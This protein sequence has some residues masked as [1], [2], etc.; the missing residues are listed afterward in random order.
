K[1]GS[2][3]LRGRGNSFRGD[4]MVAHSPPH[5]VFSLK[6]CELRHQILIGLQERGI[7]GMVLWKIRQRQGETQ[8][9]KRFPASP[10]RV[11]QRRMPVKA[12]RTKHQLLHERQMAS[13]HVEIFPLAGELS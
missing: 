11:R 2:A 10:G 13:R 3:T 1:S 9:R 5:S 7:A 6:R 4:R 8:S 12:I